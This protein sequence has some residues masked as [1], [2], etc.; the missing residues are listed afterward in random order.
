MTVNETFFFRDDK[1][2]QFFK[3]E[4]LPQLIE[5]SKK[6]F[7]KIWSAACSTGQE[8]YSIAI[9][10]SEAQKAHPHLNFEIKASDINQRI[11]ARARQGLYSKME[12]ERGLLPELKK[13]YFTE[14]SD[15]AWKINDDIKKLVT[16][17]QQNLRD[18]FSVITGNYDVIF[19]RNVLIYFDLELKT[20]ILNK[21]S[22]H[23]H[24]DS[25]LILG[26]AENI[27]DMSDKFNRV[28]NTTGIYRKA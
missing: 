12:V 11:L 2:F 23:M 13:K 4:I 8:P 18:N 17:Q 9:L 14:I 5:A 6:R 22:Q 21:V 10:M 25:Y 7:I 28:P 19:L 3:G 1:P 15:Q 24:S 20:E 16:F 26:A 27:Y